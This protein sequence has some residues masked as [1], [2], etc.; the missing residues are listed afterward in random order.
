MYSIQPLA[1]HAIVLCSLACLY[2]SS[3]STAW[4][5][6]C[7]DSRKYTLCCAPQVLWIM[8]VVESKLEAW[9][10][11]PLWGVHCSLGSVWASWRYCDNSGCCVQ[12]VPLWNPQCLRRLRINWMRTHLD[13]VWQVKMGI[14]WQAQHDTMLTLVRWSIWKSPCLET[15]WFWGE[16]LTAECEGSRIIYT[17][18]SSLFNSCR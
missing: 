6:V 11:W 8:S 15:H 5:L 3:Q 17:L 18:R 12:T 7:I 13:G 14:G 1:M 4:C 10:A 16:S 9:T 2:A